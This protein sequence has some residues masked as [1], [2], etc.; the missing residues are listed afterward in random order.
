MRSTN[1]K[2]VNYRK[3]TKNNGWVG[4][5]VVIFASILINV[6]LLIETSIFGSYFIEAKLVS[7][8]RVADEMSR[9]YSSR[10]LTPS[11]EVYAMLNEYERDYYIMD[12]N[13]TV[14]YSNGEVDLFE[15]E[16]GFEITANLDED[17]PEGVRFYSLVYEELVENGEIGQLTYSINEILSQIQNLNS[18]EMITNMDKMVLT[19]P[20]WAVFDVPSSGDKICVKMVAGVTIRDITL[21]LMFFIATGFLTVIVIIVLIIT[22]TIS[23]VK[24]RRMR[25]L[26]FTDAVTRGHN[27]T[28]FVFYGNQ[29]IRKKKNRDRKYAVIAIEIVKYTNYCLCHSLGEGEQILCRVSEVLKKSVMK[30]EYCAHNNS[31]NFAL[32]VRYIDEE[33]ILRRVQNIVTRLEKECGDHKFAFRAGVA[34]VDGSK[35]EEKDRRGRIKMDIEKEY[36]YA[37]AAAD[38]LIGSDESGVVILDDKLFEAQKWEDTVTEKQQAALDNEEFE[39]YYQ[40]KYS[41]TTN[42]LTGAEALIRWNSPEFGFVTPGRI[43]P[44]FEKNG[45]ITKIDHY[46]LKHVAEDQMKW[47]DMGYKCVPVSVNISRAHFIEETLAEQIRDVVSRVG[48]PTGL[49][50]IELTE[51]AFFDDKK[52]MIDTIEK[53]KAYGFAV[54]MDDFGSGYSSL[55]SLKDMPLDVLKLDAEFFR[56]E[57]GDER[58]RIIVKEAIKMAKKL[59]MRIVAEGVEVKEQVEFLADLGCDMIQG[60]YYAKPMPGH[61]F[62]ERMKGSKTLD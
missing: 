53:L 29:L 26:L 14:R 42:E 11:E 6:L 24:T 18:K 5:V 44:I 57:Q 49:I 13:G 40:P 12:S 27:W 3:L 50:E 54:S 41:P 35:V 38:T 9:V 46:M 10:A 51:S 52:L 1:D 2:E 59:N 61:E 28:W 62:E 25:N 43:I 30:K 34:V 4:F 56:G 23:A 48:T 32:L 22:A 15:D 45:F 16:D 36:S 20:V 60:Y 39:V 47:M 7:E 58:A 31:E 8:Y 55:N 21:W 33:R 17:V 19:I 37:C